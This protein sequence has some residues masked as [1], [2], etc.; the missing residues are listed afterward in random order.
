[1]EQTG[2]TQIEYNEI[3]IP[4]VDIDLTKSMEE[5]DVNV[6]DTAQSTITE[7]NN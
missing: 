5:E 6:V 3:V 2:K 7:T 1:M 4:D